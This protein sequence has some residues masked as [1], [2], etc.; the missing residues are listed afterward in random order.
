M[1]SA[2]LALSWRV[3][4]VL[5]TEKVHPFQAGVKGEK[6]TIVVRVS[7]TEGGEEQ[8]PE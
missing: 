4:C 2:L 1:L 6:G 5:D 8:G 7:S 3:L